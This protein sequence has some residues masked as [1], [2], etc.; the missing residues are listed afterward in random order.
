LISIWTPRFTNQAHADFWL[1]ELVMG[2][3]KILGT[4]LTWSAVR[5]VALQRRRTGDTFS[6]CPNNVPLKLSE[7]CSARPRRN[8]AT[9]QD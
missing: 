3:A 1:T 6:G 8:L 5:R 2:S 4:P 7:Y 9:A